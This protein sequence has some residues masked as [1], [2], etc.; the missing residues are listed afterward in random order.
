VPNLFEQMKNK[1]NKNKKEV[2]V[3]PYQLEKR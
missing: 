3:L 2:E 1:N